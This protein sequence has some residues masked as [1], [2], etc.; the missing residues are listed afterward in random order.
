MSRKIVAF[1]NS[2]CR[3]CGATLAKGSTCWFRKHFGMRC[4]SCGPHTS[5]DTR[6]PSK[7]QARPSSPRRPAPQPEPSAPKYEPLKNHPH[8]TPLDQR[9]GFNADHGHNL[10][11]WTASKRLPII[12]VFS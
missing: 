10:N 4:V 8:F 12:P 9:P 2:Q 7:T 1:Y 11:K 6:L 3:V 5:Q